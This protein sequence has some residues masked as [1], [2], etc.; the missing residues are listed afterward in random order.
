MPETF[1]A[2]GHRYL[3]DFQA[4]R[5]ELHFESMKSLTFAGVGQDGSR[6]DPSTVKIT[7]EPIRDQMFLVTW[8]ES[9]NTTV[10]H[11][12][13]YKEMTIITNITG[14]DGSFS[15]FRGKMTLIS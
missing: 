8:Q 6:G 2:V 1:P 13:D 9:D 5:V 11:L 7:V 10:V 3:V 14:S 15:K 4:F 12:E